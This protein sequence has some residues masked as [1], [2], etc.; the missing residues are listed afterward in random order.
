MKYHTLLKASAAPL[1]LSLAMPATSAL[2]QDTLP[3]TPECADSDGDGVCNADEE[4]GIVVTGSRIRRSSEFNSPDPITVI[5]P[6]IAQ[7][8]GLFS[9]AELLQSSAIAAGSNQI[10]S[11]ISTVSGVTNGGPGAETISLRGLGANRTLVLLNGR[12]AG[13]AGTRGGVSSFDL[14][15][16]PQSIVQNVEVL[17]TGASSVYGSDAV[18]GVVNLITKK[19]TDGLELTA[20]ASIP[21]QSG[22]EQYRLGAAWGKQFDRGH[23]LVAADYFRRD[24]LKGRDREYLD[25][26]EE[27]IFRPGTDQR[28]DPID[29]RTGS[30]R[31]A[32]F[33]WG[34]NWVYDSGFGQEGRWQFSYG[35]DNLG[36]YIPSNAGDSPGFGTAPGFFQV[37]YDAA[38]AGVDNLYHPFIAAST[39][40]PETDRYTAYVDAAYEIFDGV[41]I[42]TEL[43]FNRRETRSVSA[44]QF[45]YFT[46]YTS[47]Q[48]GAAPGV[49]GNPLH[50]GWTGPYYLSPTPITDHAGG[51]QR[52][53]YY[54]GVAF[55]KG[56]FGDGSGLL[57]D[58]NWDIWGQYSRSEGIYWSDVIYTDAINTANLQTSSCVGTTTPL[59][60]RPCIDINWTDPQF[61]Y[62][63]LTAAQRAFLYGE[64]RGETDYTQ[65]IG[66][67]ALSGSI[68]DLPAG[69]L[70][71]VIGATIRR[72][73][74]ED[75][76]GE[77]QQDNN[78]FIGSAAAITAGYTV[79][80]ELFGEIEIPLIHNTPLIQNFTINAAGRLT[81]FSA[82]QAAI[83]GSGSDEDNGN[84]T[85][86][87]GANWQ[88][89]DW[90]RFRARY[91]TSFRAPALFELFLGDQVSGGR[92]RDI[93]PCV[94]YV[95]RVANG[96]LPA[97][98]GANCAAGT[99]T[100]PGIP[101]DVNPVTP[102]V[103]PFGS[104]GIQTSV[105]T[106]GGVGV[107]DPET[108]RAYTGSII[109]TPKF[110]F[111]PN[112]DINLAVDYFNIEIN[113]EIATLSAA[114]VVGGCY[115]SDD[116]PNEPLCNFFTRQPVG[117]ASQYNLANVNV[118]FININSQRNE[119]IDTTLS[120][121]QDL[122]RLGKLNLLAQMTWQIK[123][124][125]EIFG[126]DVE[127]N[128]G[129]AGDPVW[130]GK[131]NAIWEPSDRFSI[132]YGL[133]VIGRTNDEQ[134]YIDLDA[135]GD[136]CTTG[137]VIYGDYCVELI[138]EEKFYHSL[139]GK[140]TLDKF[141]LTAGVSNLFNTRPP[142]TTI[143]GGNTLNSGAV[144]TYGQS[145]FT[146]QYDL[147]GRRF[148]INVTARY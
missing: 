73:E 67:V 37:G 129:E 148:F 134:D 45:Y 122:G 24:E 49:F 59:S 72:D 128:N 2:A 33:A 85:Y 29:P 110:D 139:S 18:A 47:D 107:L 20:F 41:E 111:L 131:F 96:T 93:D 15:V 75:I 120:I 77:A 108:S 109:L 102:G 127:D 4:S 112:T 113:G 91:G 137:S 60:N 52:V 82:T 138:G 25:C 130:T 44:A 115:A 56:N 35:N 7:A 76:P 88:V 114:N 36:A 62:G 146:S 21:E 51:R 14:N 55:A 118:R 28:A 57:G 38:S 74:I 71:A 133:D 117:T 64:D 63:N 99:A 6:Q 26:P 3:A 116:F 142:R 22:G 69:K 145:V 100:I 136:L 123:D 16:L 83:S 53:D 79:T 8:Q 132:A 119:G 140:L 147:L 97:Y 39:V 66:E 103:Q 95:A 17:K 10:T 101:A 86:S 78:N 80:K 48:N 34:H 65:L 135:E 43:L 70:Q 42:G 11:A 143:T 84:W 40:I 92:N 54:R 94:N 106:G 31:C 90:L 30:F 124:E 27:Y 23:F 19:D 144:P 89:T 58:W 1:A 12:R 9:T 98:I 141:E 87:I 126:G 105:T 104:G 46:G 81:N 121:A 50:V 125:I 32:T 13:P 68:I 61:L 5:D